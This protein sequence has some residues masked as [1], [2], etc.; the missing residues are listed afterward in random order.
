MW[1]ALEHV[2]WVETIGDTAWLYAAI[3]IVH[4]LSFFICVGS[5]AIIDLRVMGIAAHERKATE[6]A[7]Q[8][9]PWVWTGFGLAVL[10]G[11]LMFATDAGDWAPDPI[12][13]YKLIVIFLAAVFAVVIQ[14]GVPKWDQVASMPKSAKI[15]ALISLLLF[16]CAILVS[17]EIPSLDNLG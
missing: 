16:L 5:M 9:F 1:E 13:H 12:F 3:S 6:L 10:S 8:L 4:Y 17:S 15:L 14:I 11:F 7:A 2:A